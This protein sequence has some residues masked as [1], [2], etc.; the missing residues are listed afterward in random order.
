[1]LYFPTSVLNKGGKPETFV[2]DLHDLEDKKL[3]TQEW[4]ESIDPDDYIENVPFDI[5]SEVFHSTRE[6]NRESILKNGLYVRS[7]SRGISN[8][9]VQNAVF[10]SA[11]PEE[12]SE[13]SPLSYGPLLLKIDLRRMLS[14]GILSEEDLAQEPDVERQG[15]NEILEYLF[16][17]E[18]G[19]LNSYI[20]DGM[21][22]NT[23]II[24]SSIPPEYITV[25]SDNY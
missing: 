21:S 6:E 10:T 1:M 13:A 18:Y 8:R 25:E 7:D 4:C 17:L 23:I 12:V 5:P 14:D 3:T 15:K 24:Y 19:S 2:L 16:D 9:H 11:D 22:P 20:E